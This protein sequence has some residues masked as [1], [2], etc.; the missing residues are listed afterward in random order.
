MLGVLRRC[1][2]AAIDFEKEEA[3]LQKRFQEAKE[4]GRKRDRQRETVISAEE[5]EERNQQDD[6]DLANMLRRQ[7]M[8]MKT[9]YTAHGRTERYG[10]MIGN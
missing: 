4:F 7:E 3:A 1:H 10:L 2:F 6:V 5:K 9:L 8:E